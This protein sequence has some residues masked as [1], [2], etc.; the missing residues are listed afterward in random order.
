MNYINGK[1]EVTDR[2]MSVEAGTIKVSFRAA[3]KLWSSK[4]YTR[5]D[6]DVFHTAFQ[7]SRELYNKAST[8]LFDR[9][10]TMARESGKFNNRPTE[11]YKECIKPKGSRL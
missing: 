11:F 9:E 4:G 10:C 8:E 2:K 5:D 3:G 6:D 7:A 1:Y